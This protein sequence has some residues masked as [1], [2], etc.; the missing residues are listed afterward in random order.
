SPI[1]P[2]AHD[3]EGRIRIPEVTALR[4][5]WSESWWYAP[6]ILR[7]PHNLDPTVVWQIRW[8][9]G[10]DEN[11]VLGPCP[12]R[13]YEVGMT[14]GNPMTP[15][16]KY[17]PRV[18]R[19]GTDRYGREKTIFQ[20][21]QNDVRQPDGTWVAQRQDDK[22]VLLTDELTR[23]TRAANGAELA[24]YLRKNNV[25]PTPAPAPGDWDGGVG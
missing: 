12:G 22:P 15:Y 23:A 9:C 2:P 8:A 25:S 4:G 24:E 6:W 14:L 7:A 13:G 5:P 20:A 3:S 19:F 1:P 16:S 17:V 10:C 11:G 18:Y 21:S